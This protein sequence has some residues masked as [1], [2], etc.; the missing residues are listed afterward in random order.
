MKKLLILIFLASSLGLQA[1]K[2]RAQLETQALVIKNATVAGSNTPIRVGQMFQDIVNNMQN[3]APMSVASG[4]N[5]YTMY[6]SPG[7]TAYTYGDVFLVDFVNTNTGASTIAALPLAAKAIKNVDG[8]DVSAGQLKRLMWIGY[9][10][11]NFQVIG[12]SS[13]STDPTFAS[14]ITVTLGGGKTLGRYTTG[15]TIPAAGKTA[16]EVMNL[17]AIEY[18]NPAFSSF[19]VTGQNTTVEVGT[20]LSGAKT[21][22]WAIT[23]NS[24]TVSTIDI[25]D[26]TGL[27]ALVTNTANDGTQSPTIATYQLNANGT[28]QSWKGI[29]HDTNTIQ[30]INSSNF[31]VTSRFYR[32]WG[33]T[34][35]SPTTSPDVRGLPSSAFHTGASSFTLATGTTAIK[36]VVALP[37]SVTISSVIDTG[38]LNAD[39]TSSFVLTGTVNVLDA[40]STNRAYNIYEYNIGA[41]YPVSSNLTI[42][43]A[44]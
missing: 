21:F 1:Q 15:Q 24:G 13:A 40:G 10:G 8:T 30:D 22:T 44:N 31:V 42:T 18:V 19:S 33:T 37:P 12:G 29:L 34:A 28:T 43:T 11:T 20:T 17:I 2:T 14:N 23:L 7:V 25:Y 6:V 36:F 3:I 41:P 39:I 38:N 32:F 27:A 35:T 4:I 26:N 5:T 9:D 16:E